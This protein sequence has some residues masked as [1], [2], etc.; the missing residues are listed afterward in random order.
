MSI[1]RKIDDYSRT[2][3]YD[4]V[5]S[6]PVS[7]LSTDFGISDVAIAK[8]CKRLNVPRPS[9]GYWA[10]IAAGKNPR[11]APL[12]PMPD[13]LFKQQA[14]RRVPKVLNLPAPGEPL[15]PLAS[16]LMTAI[17]KAKLDDNRR[18]HLK[19]TIFPEVTVS[20]NLA[21]R[22]AH[23]FHVLLKEFEPIGIRFR[24]YHGMYQ[25]GYFERSRDR[26]YLEIAEYLVLP[27]GTRASVPSYRSTERGPK[28]SGYLT[29]S[30][31]PSW[32]GSQGTKEWFETAKVPLEKCLSQIVAGLRQYYLDIQVRQ[33][34][35][36]IQRA[37]EHAEWLERRKKAEI[38]EAI[39]RQKEKERQHAE[40]LVDTA[41]AREVTLRN[42]AKRWR[43][44]CALLQFIDE[45][46]RRWKTQSPE[47]SSDQ[48]AWMTWA[49]EIA[50]A[51]SPFTVGYP[52]PA[53]D[54]TFDPAAV[55]FGGPYPPTRDFAVDE[56]DDTE[57]EE[58]TA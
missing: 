24:K 54:G 44:S 6:T 34:Q 10:K 19:E 2:E 55:P 58:D 42:A 56:D 32:F 53:I 15:L 38:E 4:L 37:K 25:G 18:A 46:G 28:P 26:L 35:E 17:T 7:N 33:E 51:K 12:P 40:A 23:A 30:F 31:K 21:E 47:L 36:A 8:R 14:Q 57:Q 48:T 41:H 11:K 29:F 43:R 9:R 1:T 13:E 50:A 5:W 3:L 49:R 45:C 22:V 52:D 39:R 16:E 20:K 27:D